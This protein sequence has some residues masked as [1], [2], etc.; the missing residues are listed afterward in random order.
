MNVEANKKAEAA[1]DHLV[2]PKEYIKMD[3]A[4][5]IREKATREKKCIDDM[6]NKNIIN[7]KIMNKANQKAQEVDL[8]LRMEEPFYERLRREDKQRNDKK[9]KESIKKRAKMTYSAAYTGS[10]KC[11]LNLLNINDYARKDERRAQ[12]LLRK[13]NE[14]EDSK[15]EELKMAHEKKVMETSMTNFTKMCRTTTNLKDEAEDKVN[16][17]PEYTN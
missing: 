2:N 1:V 5:K 7:N 3:E 16:N 10:G 6:M 4:I 9:R 11:M 14:V 15:I 12:K 13:K 8:A 17:H